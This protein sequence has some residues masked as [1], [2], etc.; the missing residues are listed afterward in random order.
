MLTVDKDKRIKTGEAL[1]HKWFD[2]F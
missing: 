2:L 1:N